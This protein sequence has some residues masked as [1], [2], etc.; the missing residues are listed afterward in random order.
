M[1]LFLLLLNTFYFCF[2]IHGHL[3]TARFTGDKYSH[4]S[5]AASPKPKFGQCPST[6]T[7]GK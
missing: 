6:N 3:V 2:Q 5:D 4:Q 7:R 1:H